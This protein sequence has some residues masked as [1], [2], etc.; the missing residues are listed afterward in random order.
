[1]IAVRSARWPGD[2]AAVAAMDRSFVTDRRYCVVRGDLSFHLA[3]ETVDPPLHK[4]Y[5]LDLSER[6]SWDCALV[7]EQG[8]GPIGFAAARYA[9]W[10]RRVIIDHLYV[11]PYARG[12]GVGRVLLSAL[13]SF[14]HSRGARCLWLETQNV[15]YPAIQFY[16][17]AGFTLCGFDDSLYDPPLLGPE[18]TALF[19]SRAVPWRGDE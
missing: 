6:Q 5:D 11:A 2:L 1:M 17:R 19:F 9:E 4:R 15:N 10:N 8:G 18:E 13:D 16:R 7:A 3:L 12:A 14:A